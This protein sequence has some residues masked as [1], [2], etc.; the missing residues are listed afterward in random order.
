MSDQTLS[1][2]I[3]NVQDALAKKGHQLKVI[4]LAESARTA[5]QAADALGCEVAQIVKS[6]IFKTTETDQPILILASGVN[7]VDEKLIEQELG[8]KIGKADANFTRE[9]TGFAI[10]GIP[11]VGHK[12][13]I[14]TFIDQD[15]LKF[16]D[17]WAAAGTPHAIFK[18]QA[19]DLAS[20]TGGKVIRISC[21]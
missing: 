19:Q 18:F 15:L 14:K 2:S 20:L 7:R 1:K 21:N 5:Q 12:Q 3:Q 17:L 16:H 4:E 11:P 8:E 10:G 6:L 13:A 9:V